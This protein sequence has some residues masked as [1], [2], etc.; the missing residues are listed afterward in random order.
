MKTLV[1]AAILI[2][3]ILVLDSIRGSRTECYTQGDLQIG[4]VQQPWV[5]V[6]PDG[7]AYGP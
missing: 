5:C 7:V 6:G 1:V 2:V 4:G 3:C